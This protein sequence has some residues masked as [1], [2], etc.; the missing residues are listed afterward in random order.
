M[1]RFKHLIALF[2]LLLCCCLAVSGLAE[3][4]LAEVW[5][6]GVDLLFH[7]DNVTV[8]G[9]ASF[10]LDGVHFKT[11]QLHYV[12]DGNN[13][14]YGLKL[15]TPRKD[16]TERETGW[17]IIGEE[18]RD[19]FTNTNMD[20]SE[21]VYTN[22]YVMEAYTPGEYRKGTDSP[23]N[24]L[25]RRS[26]ELDA[27]TALGGS[28]VSYLAP[29][30]PEGAV[31][32]EENG[33]VKT[34]RLALAGDQLPEMAQNALSL[35]AG[36][37]ADRW[38]AQGH[39]RGYTYMDAPFESYVAPG[40]ALADGTMHWSLRNADVTFT[41]DAD[42]RLTGVSGT[43]EAESVFWDESVRTVQVQFS[44][45]AGDYGASQTAPF[46]PEDYHVTLQRN[47]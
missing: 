33:G 31:T 17:I 19:T 25:L 36:Y 22:V 41:L 1:R 6:S 8:D 16:G 40:S 29:T 28:L 34:V 21:T 44:L 12:Q 20:V 47:H 39:D 7:T 45:S 26:V 23:R 4:P 3:G 18:Y 24:T 13:S 30:L 46:S 43:A 11:A 42:G 32:A 5:S 35:A 14:Y 15:L 2:A 27:L 38:F 37:L 9:E 10:S